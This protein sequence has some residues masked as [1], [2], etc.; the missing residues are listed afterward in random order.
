MKLT[1]KPCQQEL[2]KVGEIGESI[3]QA[4]A[5]LRRSIVDRVCMALRLDWERLPLRD[6]MGFKRPARG[7]IAVKKSMMDTANKRARARAY[8]EN[9]KVDEAIDVLRLKLG[10]HESLSGVVTDQSTQKESCDLKE[11]LMLLSLLQEQNVQ[12]EEERAQAEVADDLDEFIRSNGYL[13]ASELAGWLRK[14]HG[15]DVTFVESAIPTDEQPR[16]VSDAAIVRYEDLLVICSV[17]D[18]N[19]FFG[20]AV[21]PN[22]LY[23]K[24]YDKHAWSLLTPREKA[25][26]R[27]W[28]P[29]GEYDKAAR[30]LPCT[31]GELRTFVAEAGLSWSIDEKVATESLR[32]RA[33]TAGTPPQVA[34]ESP[35][36]AALSGA[37]EKTALE[38]TPDHDA[39][40]VDLWIIHAREIAHD[41]WLRM[42][43]VCQKPTKEGIADE[44]AAKLWKSSVVTKRGKRITAN[45][46]VR[47]ALRNGWKPPQPD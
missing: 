30:P 32:E 5:P 27:A 9:L 20:Y 6:A 25:A 45:Y 19:D 42:L 22:G 40:Q 34:A 43:N 36:Q 38:I 4:D 10:E 13:L 24:M 3:V 41:I 12:N 35:E 37:P 2:L 11:R 21:Q 23:V 33:Q 14:E 17:E 46:V 26:V 28:H 47:H 16:S 29:T 39:K 18:E 7:L 44:I 8:A 31:L 1:F 15:F